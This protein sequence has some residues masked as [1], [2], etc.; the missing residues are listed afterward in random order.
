MK[1]VTILNNEDQIIGRMPLDVACDVEGWDYKTTDFGLDF[2]VMSED[3]KV[4]RESRTNENN[5]TITMEWNVGE[6][7]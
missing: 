7:A 6:V 2:G 3:Q 4:S 5:N 1:I